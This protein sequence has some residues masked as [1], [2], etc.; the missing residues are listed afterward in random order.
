MGRQ[1][2]DA[3]LLSLKLERAIAEKLVK[4]C[5]ETG[6]S[7][8]TAIERILGKEIDDYFKQPEGKRVPR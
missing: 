6:Q 2:K 8:T 7:K 3:V 1:R 4:Y 5:E